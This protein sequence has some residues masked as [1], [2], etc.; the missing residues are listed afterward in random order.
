MAEDLAFQV[1]FIMLFYASKKKTSKYIAYLSELETE[2]EILE[3]EAGGLE[4]F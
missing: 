4:I 1:T 3:T 2:N